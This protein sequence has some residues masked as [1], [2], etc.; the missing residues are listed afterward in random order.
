[1]PQVRDAVRR[2]EQTH[3]PEQA[4]ER[5]DRACAE[6]GVWLRPAADAMAWVNALLPAADA[7]RVMTAVDALATSCA[8]EDPRGADARRADALADLAGAVLDRGTDLDGTPLPTRQGRRPHLQVTVTLA[9]LCGATDTPAELAGYGP[10]PAAVA[11]SLAAEA[12]WSFVAVDARS[13]QVVDR[14]TTAYRP[15][16]AV[17]RAVVDRDVTCTFPGCRVPAERCDL[18]HAVP[19]DPSLPARQQTTTS[20]LAALCRHHHRL[21]THARWTPCHDPRTG[22]TTWLTRDGRSYTRD[23]VP[24]P[25][26]QEPLPRPYRPRLVDPDAPDGVRGY[27]PDRTEPA[28]VRPRAPVRDADPPF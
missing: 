6:R 17:V 2:A 20:N 1:M 27:P 10:V 13:G 14:S 5:H 24:V 28:A 4:L 3:A 12:C 18:D 26:E 7:M 21:K 19:F 15:S 25:F 9:A 22:V 16:A 8:P 11:R 23:P